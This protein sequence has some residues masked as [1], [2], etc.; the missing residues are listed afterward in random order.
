VI[1]R[2][3]IKNLSFGNGAHFCLGAHLAAQEVSSAIGK[4][5]PYLAHLRLSDD[6]LEL[7]PSAILNGWQR[8]RLVRA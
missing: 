8:V 1:N 3:R 7:N 2:P 5:L 6:P 4:L